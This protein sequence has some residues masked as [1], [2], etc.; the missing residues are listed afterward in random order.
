MNT[1]S[2]E[3]MPPPK[4]SRERSDLPKRKSTIEAQT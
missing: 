4:Q 1:G 2:P 3:P